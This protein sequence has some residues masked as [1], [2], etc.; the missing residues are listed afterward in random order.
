MRKI[1]ILSATVILLTLSL[2]QVEYPSNQG[3]SLRAGEDQE[4]DLLVAFLKDPVANFSRI[5][6]ERNLCGKIVDADLKTAAR[7]LAGGRNLYVDKLF[8][9]LNQEID[10]KKIEIAIYLFLHLHR[11]QGSISEKII[12]IFNQQ[13]RIFVRELERTDE[14]QTVIRM[15]SQDWGAFSPGLSRVGT[16]KFDNTLKKYAFS[17]QADHEKRLNDIEVFLHDPVPNYER[18]RSMDICLWIGIYEQ[19]LR[20]GRVLEKSILNELMDNHFAEVDRKKAEILVHMVIHCGSGANSEILADR[21]AKLFNR[22]PHVF[23]EVLEKERDWKEIVYQLALIGDISKGIDSLGNSIFEKQLR[24]YA[25]GIEA[26]QESQIEEAINWDEVKRASDTFESCPTEENAQRLLS[27]ITERPSVQQLGNREAAFLSLLE[28]GSFYK[29]VNAGDELLAESAFRLFGFFGGGALDEELR[30]AL[31]R[32]LTK[33]PVTFLELLKKYLHLFPSAKEYPVTMTEIQ[34]IIPDIKSD[35]DWVRGKRVLTALYI[36]RIKALESVEEPGLM[37][38][39]D[40]CI[41]VI[42]EIISRL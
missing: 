22:Q 3:V 1:M 36:E 42:R 2:A 18:V 12:D 13:P 7:G 38:L 30:I 31:G 17:L 5:R 28:N 14:W 6:A 34:E 35:E 20:E 15:I 41:R 40:I 27:T 37:E 26:E 8:G 11:C 21:I 25:K 33:K 29:A 10:E 39:R 4:E 16:S 24:A 19:R 32:F 9:T 23:V